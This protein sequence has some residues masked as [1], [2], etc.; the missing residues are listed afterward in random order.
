MLKSVAADSRVVNYGE[1]R[2]ALLAATVRVVARKGL[3][4]LTFRAVAEEAGVNNTLIAHHFGTRDR[5][6]AET[7][8]WTADRSVGAADLSGYASNAAVFLRALVEHMVESPE[9][10]I[11]LFEMILEASRRPELQDP[12][13]ELYRRYVAEL[14]AGRVRLGEPA[15]DALNLALFAALDGLMLQY[16]SRAITA[17]EMEDAVRA[18]TEA[19]VARP[20]APVPTA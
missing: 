9:V 7:L 2:E 4:G 19:V 11:F 3:R 20:S 8:A 16:L 14:S 1:G 12:V 5:L 13:R 15:N 17:L 10:E 6:I 18:L